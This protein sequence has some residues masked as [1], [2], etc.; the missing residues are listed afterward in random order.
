MACGRGSGPLVAPPSAPHS[1][2]S[3]TPTYTRGSR[4]PLRA[5]GLPREPTTLPAEVGNAVHPA[6]CGST[7]SPPPYSGS[8]VFPAGSMT[9]AC[10]DLAA[11]V[12][13]RAASQHRLPWERGREGRGRSKAGCW[14]N[15]QQDNA[16]LVAGMA[17]DSGSEHV[18]KGREPRGHAQGPEG[19]GGAL[20]WSGRTWGPRTH[21]SYW[22]A[23]SPLGRQLLRLCEAHRACCAVRRCGCGCGCK[24]GW[25]RRCVVAAALPP[26]SRPRSLVPYIPHSTYPRCLR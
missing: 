6:P 14:R 17:E 23:E 3:P 22:C 16:W 13:S 15:G 8:M 7:D 20:W 26:V 19:L 5:H 12:T 10:T 9:M 1:P 25:R 2:N 11:M 4:H 18:V 21:W 24:C